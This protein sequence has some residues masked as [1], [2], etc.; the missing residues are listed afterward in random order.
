MRFHRSIR[1]VTFC[2]VFLGCVLAAVSAS[3]LAVKLDVRYAARQGYASPPV[4]ALD[5][6]V[7]VANR[8]SDD[9]PAVLHPS[10]VVCALDVMYARCGC[11]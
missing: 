9:S 6:V 7:P 8:F 10:V 11:Q 3:L 4:H 1:I 2:I 5:L